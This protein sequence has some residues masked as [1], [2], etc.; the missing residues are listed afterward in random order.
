M[1]AH[2]CT[3]I[4]HFRRRAGYLPHIQGLPCQDCMRGAEGGN[5]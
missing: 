1:P 2:L 5:D 3:I 4:E